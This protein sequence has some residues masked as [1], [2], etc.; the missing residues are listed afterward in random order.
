MADDGF[1]LIRLIADP[2]IMRYRDQRLAPTTASHSSM[3]FDAQACRRKSVR[4]PVAEIAIRK[5][6]NGQAAR[7]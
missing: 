1:T 5:E 4:K 3:S 7:S 2:G 6:G